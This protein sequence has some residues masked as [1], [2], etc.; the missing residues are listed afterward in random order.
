MQSKEEQKDQR[1]LGPPGQSQ[2]WNQAEDSPQ[3][4]GRPGV[5]ALPEALINLCAVTREMGTTPDTQAGLCADSKHHI[6]VYGPSSMKNVSAK[7]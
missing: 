6:C 5:P 2:H 4:L 1:G 7:P 3:G